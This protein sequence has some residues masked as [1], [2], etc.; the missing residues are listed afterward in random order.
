[1]TGI[2]RRTRARRDWGKR[3]SDTELMDDADVSFDEFRS[4]LADL[5][6]V[7]RVT[8]T[9]RPVLAFFDR[10]LSARAFPRA[11]PL[12]VIDVGSG[13]GDLLRAVRRW[14]RRRG[15]AMSL[16]GVD[17]SPWSRRA[18]LEATPPDDDIDWITADA[19]SFQPAHAPDVIVSSQFTHHLPDPAIEHFL[20]WMEKRADLAWFVNDLHRHPVPYHFFRHF[21]RLA[22]YHHFVRHDGPVSI[23]RS[24]VPD[25][26]RRALQ[27]AGIGPE[28]AT[29]R[30]EI[31][32]RLTVERIKHA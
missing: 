20:R 22:N 5:A 4:C 14:S 23:A 8:L 16:T 15:L 12:R 10:L 25:D 30:W 28:D 17:L 27:G 3:S 11:R 21:S 19:F 1:M 32:F 18:A 2:L 24:F 31:P 6:R 9:H 26:W 13:Y 29:I 7:N